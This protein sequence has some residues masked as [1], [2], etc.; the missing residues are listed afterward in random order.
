MF[1]ISTN[2]KRSIR[3]ASICQ[4]WLATRPTSGPGHTAVGPTSSGA[5]GPPQQSWRPRANCS[6]GRTAR[7]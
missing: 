4:D 2:G 3:H 5:Y 6:H 7:W 1:L